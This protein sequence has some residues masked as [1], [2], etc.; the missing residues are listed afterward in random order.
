MKDKLKSIM[1][2]IA[3][4]GIIFFMIFVLKENNTLLEN[5]KASQSIFAMDTYMELLAYGDNSEDAVRVAVEEIQHLDF[6][7]STGSEAS[8]V[9]ILNKNKS[10]QV[11]ADYSYL[12]QRS[13][14]LCESTD[15]AFDITVYPVMKAW[16]FVGKN[17]N[18][19]SDGEISNLLK[20]VDATKIKYDDKTNSVELPEEVEIDFGGIAKGYAS[21]RV[22]QIMKEQGIESALL[23]LGGNVQTIGSKTDGSLWKVAIKS[24][25]KTDEYIG[26]ISVADKAVITSGGY[27]RYFEE[28]GNSYH[29]IIDP[30][31]GKPAQNGLISVTIVS[32]DGT[33]ADGLS[34]SL[35]VMGKDKSIDYWKAHSNEFDAVLC[36]DKGMLYVTEGLE[37][38]FSSESKYEVVRNK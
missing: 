19:P 29:H 3:V 1:I 10:G 32:D 25:Y 22:S 17:Y 6:L 34:T 37:G 23:N 27:E 36:D 11:S 38:Y 35:Y 5:K 13:M 4:I 7:L 9:T 20:Y 30:K 31:T 12:L 8:E 15:G 21:E 28:N 33:L 14:E 2:T 24:P 16:G 26:V 18:V